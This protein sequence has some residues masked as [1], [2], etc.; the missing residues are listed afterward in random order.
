MDK[1]EAI[2]L[3]GGSAMA[4][5]EAIGISK[6]AVYQWPDDLPPTISDRVLAALWRKSQG[7]PPPQREL[8]HEAKAA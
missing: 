4:A 6:S 7:L 1:S 2:G 5:A 8:D 3:L